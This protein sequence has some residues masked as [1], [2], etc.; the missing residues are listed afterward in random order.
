[1]AYA[2]LKH[3]KDNVTAGYRRPVEKHNAFTA[4]SEQE[5][6]ELAKT[7][8]TELSKLRG[9]LDLETRNY[10]EYRQNVLRRLHELHETVAS[11]FGE[12]KA[13]CLPFSDKGMKIEEMMD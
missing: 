4:K 7:H 1:M 13:Q 12:V 8:A 5:K 10:T 6:T 9:H 2:N 11:S 3:E